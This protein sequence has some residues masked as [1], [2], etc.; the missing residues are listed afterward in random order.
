M[1]FELNIANEEELPGEHVEGGTQGLDPV[2]GKVLDLVL[3]PVLQ[4]V[5]RLLRF[6]DSS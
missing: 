4:S 6:T 5:D 2:T 1:I 3:D